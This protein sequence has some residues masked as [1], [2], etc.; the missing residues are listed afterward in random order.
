MKD[1]RFTDA[2]AFVLSYPFL[3][4]QF[5][6]LQESLKGL[7]DHNAFIG[8]HVSRG[9]RSMLEVFQDVGKQLADSDIVQFATFD[10]MFDGIRNTLRGGILS[11]IDVADSNLSDRLAV[12][13]M[14]VLL[15]LKYVKNFPTTV[16]HI[17]TLAGRVPRQRQKHAQ[18][19]G[20]GRPRHACLPVLH[21][22][23]RG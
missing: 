9:E 2:E 23:G 18:A 16:E 15:M 20:A 14:K 5:H 12:R 13:I 3:A 21:P 7:S 8:R 10:Q 22:A 1:L 6:Y 4:Y 17:T 11:Q 19:E